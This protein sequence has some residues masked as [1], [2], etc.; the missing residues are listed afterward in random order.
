MTVF[1][2]ESIGDLYEL[3]LVSTTGCKPGSL[4]SF[5]IDTIERLYSVALVEHIESDMFSLTFYYKL[6]KDGQ[7]TPKLTKLK[8]GDTLE[9]TFV[10]DYFLAEQNDSVDPKAVFIG[11]GTGVSPFISFLLH[12]IQTKQLYRNRKLLCYFGAR[13][14][15]HIPMFYKFLADQDVHF[16]FSRDDDL[17]DGG[18]YKKSRIVL[19]DIPILTN[20]T[21][22]ICGL[23]AMVTDV[24][25]YLTSHGV[26]YTKIKTESYYS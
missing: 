22:Y 14:R 7:L 18:Q 10:N 3:V 26:H 9:A 2:Q 8:H 6:N 15:N 4:F 12:N 11:T 16:Y 13:D 24:Q 17:K 20:F 1:H 5:K 25:S 21:Y 19:E 23:E